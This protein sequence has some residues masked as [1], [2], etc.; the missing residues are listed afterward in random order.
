MSQEFNPVWNLDSIFPGGSLSTQMITELEALEKEFNAIKDE[1]LHLDLSSQ[2]STNILNSAQSLIARLMTCYAFLGCLNAANTEDKQ[3]L[4]HLGRISG[5]VAKMDDVMVLLSKAFAASDDIQW[6]NFI[7]Q[8]ALSDITFNLNEMRREAKDLLGLEQEMLINTLSVNGYRE[9]GS[10]YD[11]I[12]TRLR[13]VSTNA[14]GEEEQLSAGQALNRLN[15]PN[16]LVR[17]SLLK[18]WEETWQASTDL[19]AVELNAIAGFRLDVYR[20]RGWH[21]FMKEPLQQ[22][23]MQQATLDAMWSTISANK[24]RLVAYLQR[25]KELLGV[26]ELS[27]ADFGAP[28]TLTNDTTTHSYTEA[29]NFVIE[30]FGQFSPKMS[31]YAKEA[32]LNR[33]V[34]AENRPHKGIGAF[35]TSVPTLQQ[36]RVFMTFDG[37]VNG[38]ST[39]AHELGHAFHG[40]AMSGLPIIANNIG[41]S[42]A[43]TASTFAEIVVSNASIAQSTSTLQRL[44]LIED[45]INRAAT[46]MMNIHSRFIFETNFYK[47]RSKKQ[48]T[49]AELN[50]IMLQAQKEAY[51]DSLDIWHPTFWLSKGHFHGTGVPF[52]NFPYTFGFLFANGIYAKALQ[53][54]IG[55]E[56]SYIELLRHTGSMTVEDLAMRFLSADLTKPDFWQAAIDVALKDFDD[57]MTMSDAYLLIQNS[58]KN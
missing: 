27:W 58:K 3:V 47:E 7:A 20:A 40:F 32:I 54:D 13:M 35:C 19:G 33:W 34:E 18:T 1:C 8:E 51:V 16:P 52:Y 24:G 42:V 4:I 48:V 36:E 44:E 2:E 50:E 23:R 45:K 37:S 28:L 56:D 15:D 5:L 26:S 10:L 11:Q 41:M 9:W 57:Y 30:Q 21:D 43:E 22:N 46:M 6:D 25:K 53:S 31:A 55:F 17:N 29:A 14:A 12:V 49:A 38:I 39:L